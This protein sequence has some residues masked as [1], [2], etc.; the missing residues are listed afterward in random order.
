MK[1]P[2]AIMIDRVALDAKSDDEFEAHSF[3]RDAF[4]EYQ[5][6]ILLNLLRE[7]RKIQSQLVIRAR[8]LGVFGLILSVTVLVVSI[9]ERLARWHESGAMFGGKSI[10]IHSGMHGLFL[11][12]TGIIGILFLLL[13]G[14]SVWK[15][16]R[17][18][19]T[20][21]QEAVIK[22]LTQVLA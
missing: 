7:R 14:L 20:E 4:I 5:L 22:K 8:F 1:D 12:L 3:G 9:S 6:R 21:T 2:V 18:R 11:Q 15:L 17:K 13:S 19:R 10:A 16:A